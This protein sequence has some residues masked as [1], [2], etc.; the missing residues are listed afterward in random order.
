MG[1]GA[2]SSSTAYS[3]NAAYAAPT[4]GSLSE[5]FAGGSAPDAQPTGLSA[6]PSDSAA[7]GAAGAAED[8]EEDVAPTG[9]TYGSWMLT[10]LLTGLPLIGII[11]L[12]VLA[13]GGSA[14]AWRRNWARALLTWI[15]IIFALTGILV[16]VAG[17][18]LYQMLVG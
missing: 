7:A 13:F 3:S 11:Y 4:T 8:P 15:V 1:A 6:A 5:Y 12:C 17:Q 18:V 14:P 2:V 10:L 16:V 9:G